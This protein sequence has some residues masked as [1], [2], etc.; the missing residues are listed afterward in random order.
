[1][2]QISDEREHIHYLY[3]WKHSFFTHPK[4]L[5]FIH[6]S[7]NNH[8]NHLVNFIWSRVYVLRSS[9]LLSF[10]PYVCAH[11]ELQNIH[12]HFQTSIFIHWLDF[13]REKNERLKIVLGVPH[14]TPSEPHVFSD[15]SYLDSKFNTSAH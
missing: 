4:P 13:G 9:L 7:F 6:I 2:N 1:M 8:H 10:H 15:K 11:H 5:A 3:K 14:Q 12:S